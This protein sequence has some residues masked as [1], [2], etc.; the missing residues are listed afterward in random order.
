MPTTDLDNPGCGW[1]R[2]PHTRPLRA[3]LADNYGLIW[4]AGILL[5][6]RRFWPVGAQP[7]FTAVPEALTISMLFRTVS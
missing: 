6:N 2:P 3:G 4:T 5:R 1:T 7:S